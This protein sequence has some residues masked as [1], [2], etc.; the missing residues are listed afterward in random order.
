MNQSSVSAIT[1]E[2][3]EILKKQ[4]P[5]IMLIFFSYCC[6]DESTIRNVRVTRE[7]TQSDTFYYDDLCTT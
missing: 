5:R 3:R 1:W 2:C 7:R 4:M 6:R